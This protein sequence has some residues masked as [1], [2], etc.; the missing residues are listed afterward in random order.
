M[1]AAASKPVMVIGVDDSECAIAT[2]E[3]TL[4]QFFSQ[5][6]R[7]HPF[8]LVVVHVKPSPDVFVGFSGS[9]SKIDLLP[10]SSLLR[11]VETYQA[12]DGDLKRKAARTIKIAR[13]ICSSKSVC[14]V[15]FEVEEGDARYVL[16]EAAIKHRA[17]VLVVG[18]RG[19]GG[20]KRAFLGSVSDYCVH[21]APCTVMIVK[22]NHSTK[23]KV[24][25]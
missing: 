9:G 1:A 4:D 2:L 17:S 24:L 5:T 8:K 7:I 3:W 18:S 25:K 15:E 14:D 13:E 10:Q 19:H 22:I 11:S 12:F 16:C 6:I 21:Q 20:M 23:T